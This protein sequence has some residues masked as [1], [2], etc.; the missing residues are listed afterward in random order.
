MQVAYCREHLKTEDTK[1]GTDLFSS[2]YSFYLM[3]HHGPPLV[4]PETIAGLGQLSAV[5][6]AERCM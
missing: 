2:S 3:L 4:A 5:G 1:F 6:W